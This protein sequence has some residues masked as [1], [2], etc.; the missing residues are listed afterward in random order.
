M[1]VKHLILSYLHV[2]RILAAQQRDGAVDDILLPLGASSDQA[3]EFKTGPPGAREAE[4]EKVSHLE[5]AALHNIQ[6][7]CL[8]SR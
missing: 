2:F 3:F 6:Q 7:P 1:V 5:V 4:C 8:G